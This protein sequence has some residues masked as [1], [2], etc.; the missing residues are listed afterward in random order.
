LAFQDKPTNLPALFINSNAVD[1]PADFKITDALAL[2]GM[3]FIFEGHGLVGRGAVLT[4]SATGPDRIE[5]L[6]TQWR[7]LCSKAEFDGGALGAKLLAFGA[8]AFDSESKVTSTLTIPRQVL[9]VRNGK[10]TLTNITTSRF[11]TPTTLGPEWFAP[12][13]PQKPISL[14]PGTVSEASFESLVE[15]A[16]RRIDAGEVEKIVMARE[17][18][19]KISRDFDPRQ[20]IVRL[21]QLYP[22]CWTYWVNRNFGASPELLIRVS[23]RK[24]N[25]RVLAGSA[26][27]G[28]DPTIDEAIATALKA[29]AKNRHEHRLAI[30]SLVGSLLPY[31]ANLDA[32]SEPFSLALPNLWHLASDVR[33]TLDHRNSS[34]DV[35]AALHPTAAV[36]GT[37]LRAAQA[38]IRQLEPFDRGV[39][40]G[41]VGW[42]DSTGDGEWVI[43]LRGASIGHGTITAMAGCGIVAGSDPAAEL[44]ETELK[45]RPIRQALA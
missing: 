10:A 39:Y 36:A 4:L 21:T 32:D 45:L 33:G 34:L 26:A 7:E 22:S 41:P 11:A 19:A 6:A 43:A 42:I 3:A 8:I 14:L 28:T 31:C 17:V 23:N 29:S 18:T 2:D 27:R 37:P 1:V 13:S 44:A 30:D 25:A 40:A 5:K 35:L 20:A 38:T 12:V 15:S 24:I 16:L 9:T